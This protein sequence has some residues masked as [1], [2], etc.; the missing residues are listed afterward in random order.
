MQYFIELINNYK[1]LLKVRLGFFR[2]YLLNNN[3]KRTTLYAHYFNKLNVKDNLILYESSNAKTI[4]GNPYALFN[5][6]LDNPDY[7]DYIHI[8]STKDL[9]KDICKKFS[10]HKNVKFV[11]YNSKE[12]L[13]YLTSAKYL[14]NDS[15][16]PYYFIKK[17]DQIY[18]NIWHGTP[19]KS[20]GKDV[21]ARIGDH[22]NVQRNFLHT[23]YL[24][25]SNKYTSEVLLKSH[26]IYTIYNGYIANIGYP[27]VDL[28]FHTNK[29]NLKDLLRVNDDE[30]IV[31]Y[32]PTWR[33]KSPF[34]V[35]NRLNEIF[36]DIENIN[37]NLPSNYRLF[38]K[39][40]TYTME[41]INP[42]LEKLAIPEH[43]EINEM[44]SITDVLITDYSSVFFEFLSTKRPILFFCYDKNEYI[45]ERGLYIPLED[46]PGPICETSDEIISA[47]K[48]IKLTE[49]KYAK[50]YSDFIKKFACHD[51]GNASKRVADLI[52][53]KKSF[54]KNEVYKITDERE[55]LLFYPG[56]LLNDEVTNDFIN[57]VNCI[58]HQTYDIFVFLD[59][60]SNIEI[61]AN[62]LKF[63]KHVKILFKVGGFNFSLHNYYWHYRLL[64]KEFS[65]KFIEKNIPRELYINET[66]RLFATTDFDSV[67]DFRGEKKETATF[68]AFGNFKRKYIYSRYLI[69]DL[70]T[71]LIP[72]KKRISEKNLKIIFSLFKYFDKVFYNTL[73]EKYI[74]ENI[75]NKFYEDKIN[76]K[77]L[78]IPVE[79]KNI[80]ELAS[81]DV[82]IFG[83]RE[84]HCEEYEISDRRI[85]ISGVSSP[86]KNYKNFVFVGKL[87]YNEGFLKMLNAFAKLNHQ[88]ENT[89]LYIIGQGPLELSLKNKVLKLGLEKIIFVT[90]LNN[91]FSILNW[92]D[93]VLLPYIN[94]EQNSTLIEALVL[95]KPIISIETPHSRA[96]LDETYGIFVENSVEGL[97]KGMIDFIE[98]GHK[99]KYFDFV[100]Y[101]DKALKNFYEE[102][103]N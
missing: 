12:Y 17:E 34:D 88:Y 22:K 30:K 38:L 46:L 36:N 1:H 23:S 54:P 7:N 42:E 90:S 13:K 84:Y 41:F 62:I 85:A 45:K 16:F 10:T 5:F 65:F 53:N 95:Q 39:L 48:N 81:N 9:N 71:I 87:V 8:W 4:N 2:R 99:Q 11:L 83:D 14:I 97:S 47:L 64:E 63:S 77:H 93:C 15:T 74:N 6:L 76:L 18:V 55:K 26:D 73:N 51:D 35:E 57:L 80:L 3:F 27:S 44:L 37:N 59:K 100:E 82:E 91:Y 43:L 94:I 49:K 67:L 21:N 69:N 58:D 52:F 103:F 72:T 86:D 50:T 29:K 78:M 75:L 32:A 28:L 20:M 56:S 70:E 61:Q 79:Y 66:R 33:G 96:I 68:F 60:F 19:L 98:T 31:L 101:N 89:R 24:I 102:V 25:N 92:C 40:H